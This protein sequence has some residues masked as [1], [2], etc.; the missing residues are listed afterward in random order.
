MS[1]K[2]R[3]KSWNSHCSRRGLTL[4]EMSSSRM[5]VTLGVAA[6]DPLDVLRIARSFTTP[7][8]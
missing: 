7:P 4:N 1:A 3:S 8:M 5:R 2:I 6:F